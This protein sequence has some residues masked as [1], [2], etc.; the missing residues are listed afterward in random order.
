MDADNSL[1]YIDPYKMLLQDVGREFLGNYSCRGYNAA[2]WGE[3]SSTKFLEVYYEPGNA[4]ISFSPI[5]PLKGKGMVLACSVDELGNPPAYRYRWLRGDKPV[6]D[7]VTPVWNIDPVGLDSRNNFSCHAIN[8]G[9]HGGTATTDIVVHAAPA[10]IQKL[11]PYT[12]ALYSTSEISLSCRV[13]CF[14]L[15]SIYWFKDG[16]EITDDNFKYIRRESHVPMEPS[17]GDFESVLSVLVSESYAYPKSSDF[18]EN[19][20]IHST[21]IFHPGRT[22]SWTCTKTTQTILVFHQTI[23]LDQGFAARHTSTWS[24]SDPQSLVQTR[25]S[26]FFFPINRSS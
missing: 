19:F 26:Q 7:V 2:G 1:C 6:Y 24:V 23:P 17:T 18:K 25:I 3:E 13:E 14:P 8:E 20:P 11:P 10:F 5:Q 21:S 15:C 9:G 12:G 16:L 22:R 4:S